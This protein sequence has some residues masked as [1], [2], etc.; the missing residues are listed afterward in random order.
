MMRKG[1]RSFLR[2]LKLQWYYPR[3]HRNKQH[4][5]HTD[6]APRNGQKDSD[7][8]GVCHATHVNSSSSS[9][10]SSTFVMAYLQQ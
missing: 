3:S 1:G 4:R 6:Y 2:C 8:H 9:S 7:F 10:S 5:R